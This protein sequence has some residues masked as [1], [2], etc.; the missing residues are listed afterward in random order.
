[1]PAEVSGRMYAVIN[2]IRLFGDESGK[3]GGFV[4][5]SLVGDR[6]LT[7]TAFPPK[8]GG[9]EKQLLEYLE[10]QRVGRLLYRETL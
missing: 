5:W 2:L 3:I 7:S 1:V 4:V 8:L 10:G 9:G 6:W